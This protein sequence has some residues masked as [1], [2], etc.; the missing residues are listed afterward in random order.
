MGLRHPISELALTSLVDI[1]CVFM[2]VRERV[3]VC[4]VVY[5]CACVRVCT[6]ACVRVQMIS[7]L[8]KIIGLFCRILSLL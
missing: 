5:V 1:M 7:T 4:A 6:W 2:C 8:L 3:C